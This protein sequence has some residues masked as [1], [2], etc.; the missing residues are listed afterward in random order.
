MKY[1]NTENV[2]YTTILD[3]LKLL[4]LIDIQSVSPLQEY[5]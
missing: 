5:T 1:L 4:V 3:P 2:Y